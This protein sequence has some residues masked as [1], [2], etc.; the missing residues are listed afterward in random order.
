MK[1]KLPNGLI[2][3]VIIWAGSLSLAFF[4]RSMPNDFNL[5]EFPDI[6]LINKLGGYFFTFVKRFLQYVDFV[7][8]IF[9]TWY[10][11]LYN[12]LSGI[13]SQIVE[14]YESFMDLLNWF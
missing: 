7:A 4:L 12:Y 13:L 10:N 9:D 14:I 8:N 1:K 3:F 2:L 6:I 5:F 11:F